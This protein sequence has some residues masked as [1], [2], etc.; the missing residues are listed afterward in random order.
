MK[1]RA[2]GG[3]IFVISGGV[4]ILFLDFLVYVIKDWRYVQLGMGLLPF[5]Q[6]AAMW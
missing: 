4:G 2:T 3:L 5:L 6:L 1:Y